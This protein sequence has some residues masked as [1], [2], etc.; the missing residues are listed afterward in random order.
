MDA[1]VVEE[2][3]AFWQGSHPAEPDF[4]VA[5]DELARRQLQVPQDLGRFFRTGPRSEDTVMVMGTSDEVRRL[6]AG[7]GN[8]G[9]LTAPAAS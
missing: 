5:A 1:Q 2:Y 9:G 7:G 3:N 8:P 6:L 4:R